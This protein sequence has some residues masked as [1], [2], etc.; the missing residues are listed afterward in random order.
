MSV[1]KK[2]YCAFCK[3]PR[4]AYLKKHVSLINF[5]L[6]L[7]VSV[8]L[9]FL[10]WGEV[11][12]KA[13]VFF[14]FLLATSEIFIQIRWR[15]S[16]KCP[17][18]GFDPVLYLRDRPALVEKVKL[19]LE[20]VKASPTYMLTVANPLRNLP[21]RDV[22]ESRLEQLQREKRQIV[23]RRETV[24]AVPLESSSMHEVK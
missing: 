11:E 18:C 24:E 8:L 16:V 4:K 23:Q 10:F 3:I 12:P 2:I 5:V 17:H 9:M 14:V 7:L 19:R 1:S 6:S 20:E 21:H 15:L 13:A 22:V